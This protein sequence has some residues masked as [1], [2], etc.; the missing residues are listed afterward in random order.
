MLKKEQ[1]FKTIADE[2]LT[3]VKNNSKYSTYVKYRTV[4]NKYMDKRLGLYNMKVITE[5]YFQTEIIKLFDDEN[6]SDS[7]H[8]SIYC[9]FNQIMSY[10]RRYYH[11]PYIKLSCKKRKKNIRHIEILN[12]SEQAN[13]IKQLY[14]DMNSDK[15]GIVICLSTGLRLGEICALRWDDIDLKEKLI[16]VNRTVQRIA[17]DGCDTRTRLLESEPKSEFSKREIPISDSLVKLISAYYH[18]GEYVIRCSGPMEPRTYQN[19]FHKYLKYAGVEQKNFHILR[20]TFATNCIDNGADIKCLS[21]I[22]GHS[23]VNITLNRYVHPS[24]ETKRKQM[25]LLFSVYS[26]YLIK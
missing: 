22:L 3:F 13:L 26:N 15:L 17:V 18:N 5:D 1:L 7:L 25:D 6:V 23:D 21:E 19:H 4:Y 8:K 9:V 11:L 20:H 2:W 14:A 10:G 12:K 16:H 24:L